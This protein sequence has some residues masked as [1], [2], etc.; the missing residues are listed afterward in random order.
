MGILWRLLF[1][2]DEVRDREFKFL[3]FSRENRRQKS[4]IFWMIIQDS[5]NTLIENGVNFKFFNKIVCF[6]L[7]LLFI[8]LIYFL[9]V[10]LLAVPDVINL[11]P[12]L[13]FWRRASYLIFAKP[14]QTSFVIFF[15]QVFL[16]LFRVIS[17][18]LLAFSIS[19]QTIYLIRSFLQ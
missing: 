7:I 16:S 11:D 4:L 9:L 17:L 8:F 14:P 13:D 12:L 19:K 2:N 3:G 5:W 6:I 10:F 18:N 1:W 15:I